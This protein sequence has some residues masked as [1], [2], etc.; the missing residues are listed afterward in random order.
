[1]FSSLAPITCSSMRFLVCSFSPQSFIPVMNMNLSIASH[2]YIGVCLM[3]FTKALHTPVLPLCILAAKTTWLRLVTCLP[4]DMTKSFAASICESKR[5]PWLLL[6]LFLYLLYGVSERTFS[7]FDETSIVPLFSIAHHS[8]S[9]PHTNATNQPRKALNANK[10]RRINH[11]KANMPKTDLMS[12]QSAQISNTSMSPAI[13]KAMPEL[14]S[15]FMKYHSNVSSSAVL[16]SSNSLFIF[17]FLFVCKG[18]KKNS[19]HKMN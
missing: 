5:Y 10:H 15:Q 2:L 18:T 3:M 9:M 14:F 4:N 6:R 8:I 12:T 7:I 16:I 13:A 11:T 1:M 17:S 19:N